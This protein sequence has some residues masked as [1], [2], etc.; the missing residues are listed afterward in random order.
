MPRRKDA[1]DW[2]GRAISLEPSGEA[3]ID[4][5]RAAPID[6]LWHVIGICAELK[7]DWIDHA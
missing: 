6:Q 4:R 5:R 3:I 7:T 2:R 1:I